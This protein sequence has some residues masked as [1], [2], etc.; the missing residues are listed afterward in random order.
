MKTLTR[1]WLFYL[2]GISTRS[3][4][5]PVLVPQCCAGI[6]TRSS[7][8][9]GNQYSLLMVERESVLAPHGCAGISTRSS[10]L[11]GNQYSLTVAIFYLLCLPH[12]ISL[13]DNIQTRLRSHKFCE[14]WRIPQFLCVSEQLRRD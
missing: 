4:W 3:L 10:W 9:R 6:S 1:F 7:L 12:C 2:A 11:C 13:C 14:F 8:L 5:L